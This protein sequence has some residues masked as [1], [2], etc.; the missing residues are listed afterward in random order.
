MTIEDHGTDRTHRR[1][2]LG[3]VGARGYTGEALLRLL[4]GHDGI[5]IAWLGSRGQA[6]TRVSDPGRPATESD[7]DPTRDAHQGHSTREPL[8]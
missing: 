4:A 7:D 1:I 3:M 5:E 6:G 2:R 8:D